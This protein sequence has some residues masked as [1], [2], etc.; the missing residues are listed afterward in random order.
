VTVETGPAR[1][2]ELWR[3]PVKSL[4]GE[5]LD[6]V[7]VDARGVRGD[8][9]FAVTDRDGKIGSGKTTR[10]FRRLPGLFELCARSNGDDA[11]VRLPDGRE[12]AV[13]DARL[14]AFLS[15]RYGDELHVLRESTVSH[16]DAAPLHLLTTAALHW[17]QEAL[18]ASVIDRRRFRPNVVV[19]VEGRQV[20]E[21][22][23]VDRRF[24]LGGALVRIV[25]RMERCVM[26]TNAQAELPKD[27]SVLW[28][29]TKLN[30]M[31]LGVSAAVERP[32]TI[33]VG[34]AMRS[35]DER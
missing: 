12:L 3:Y 32:G 2:L 7:E 23:W 13:G 17:L 24:S 9:L 35:L 29:V 20:V 1:V 11:L 25:D 8:R 14:D 26:A 19:A 5:R 15:E 21:D 30:G 10:R 28:A 6:A 22:G 33:R 34:D 31:C 16:M 4:L 18:P 27:P